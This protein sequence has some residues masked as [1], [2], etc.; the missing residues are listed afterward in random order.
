MSGLLAR[1][2]SRRRLVPEQ[3]I[4]RRDVDPA[5]IA[6]ADDLVHLNAETAD[7]LSLSTAERG[8][9]L[10]TALA[11]ILATEATSQAAAGRYRTD[12]AAI[13]RMLEALRAETLMCLIAKRADAARE[14]MG[15]G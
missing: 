4:A 2:D 8:D 9:Q 15:L 13:D 12:T 6:A 11:L 7:L 3:I 14:A 10:I 1:A 5:I